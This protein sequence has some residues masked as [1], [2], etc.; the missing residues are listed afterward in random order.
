MNVRLLAFYLPQFHPIPENDL[1]WGKGFTE[2]RV[3]AAARPLFGGHQQPK[4][5]GELGFYDLRLPE[6]R[7]AQA[8]LA[9]EHGIEGFCYW[10]YWLGNGQQLLERPFAEVL[11]S[12]EPQ[13]PFC[14]GWAN[15]PWKGVFFGAGGRTLI[16][17]TYPG[18]EDHRHHFDY[19]IK[20]FADDRYITVEGKPLLYIYKPK[21]IP[22]VVRMTDFWR[23]LAHQR[24]LK[25]LHLVG[26]G[27]YP[28]TWPGF[29]FDAGTYSRHRVVE[30]LWPKSRIL[31]ALLHAY[32]KARRQPAVYSYQRA[33]AYVHV[34]S[35]AAIRQY[36]P[37]VPNWDNT[38][39]LGRAGV[40]LSEATPE[41]FQAHVRDTL[42]RITHKPFEHR[43]AF[44]KSWNE[45]AEGNY[46]EPDI[47]YG[48]RYLE[49]IREE[50]RRCAC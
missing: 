27:L 46:L 12:G 17:Q 29:G 35:C 33:M 2:W 30:R 32:R 4:M 23:E 8:E 24:G 7:L 20:A 18:L 16:D 39:R 14:L 13:F 36:P 21:D 31:R 49:I 3:V 10:H 28:D 48:R 22:E 43:I 1:W 26:E 34:P 37:I 6:A 50:A 11:K 40:V 41:L 42:Q 9:R 38:P 47:K 15:H 19:F 45:W 44:I 5:P 25:G